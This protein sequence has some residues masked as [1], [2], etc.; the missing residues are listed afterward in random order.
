METRA[1]VLLLTALVLP[2]SGCASLHWPWS[3]DREQAAA[4]EPVATTEGEEPPDAAPPKV[5]EPVVER[6]KIRVNRIDAEIRRP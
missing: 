2:V 6:R 1:R 4:E 5:I 3:K